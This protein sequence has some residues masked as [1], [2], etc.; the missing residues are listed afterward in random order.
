MR[1]CCRKYNKC[2]FIQME[3]VLL[4]FTLLF[5]GNKKMT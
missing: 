4:H 1:K 5:V 3:F 2:I